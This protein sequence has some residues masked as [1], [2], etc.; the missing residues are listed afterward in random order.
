VRWDAAA[1]HMTE[2]WIAENC[3]EPVARGTKVLQSL[4]IA[5]AIPGLRVSDN[6][7]NDDAMS[8]DLAA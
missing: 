3:R 1:L 2:N 6:A 5:N 7:S 4:P 8:G